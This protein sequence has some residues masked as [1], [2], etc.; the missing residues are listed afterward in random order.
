MIF[1]KELREKPFYF[2]LE[3]PFLKCHKP[4][5]KSVS[6]SKSRGFLCICQKKSVPR[7]ESVL[8]I[9]NPFQE[10]IQGIR[11]RTISKNLKTQRQPGKFFRFY[12]MPEMVRK[13]LH[14]F[15]IRYFIAR[16][17]G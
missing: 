1:V 6:H 15:K 4:K 13:Y 11:Q 5:A 9:I 12:F 3:I 14:R 10:S 8:K 7:S 2:C 16:L 17:Q